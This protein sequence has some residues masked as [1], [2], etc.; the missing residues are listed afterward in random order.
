MEEI[1]MAAVLLSA[2]PLFNHFHYIPAPQLDSFPLKVAALL[3]PGCHVQVPTQKCLTEVALNPITALRSL[4]QAPG[5]S[6][7]G[8]GHGLW[9][10]GQ[11]TQLMCCLL[12]S[13]NRIWGFFPLSVPLFSDTAGNKLMSDTP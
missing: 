13:D 1:T 5:W 7:D 4:P 12:L 3:Q 2:K 11:L 9:E 6:K 10:W 8:C